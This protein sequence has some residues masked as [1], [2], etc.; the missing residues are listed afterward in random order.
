MEPL[1]ANVE[2]Q[3]VTVQCPNCLSYISNPQ[4]LAWWSRKNI[5]SLRRFKC[6]R[7]KRLLQIPLIP[8]SQVSSTE[9]TVKPGEAV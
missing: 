1:D 3:N 4:G 9:T 2:V 8:R 5:L 6:S 7:C